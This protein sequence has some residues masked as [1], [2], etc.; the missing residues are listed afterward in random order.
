M[1][2]EQRGVDYYIN[3]IFESTCVI[4]I[5]GIE[6]IMLK[7]L[8]PNRI[9]IK[10]EQVT[11][12]PGGVVMTET[13]NDPELLE[14]RLNNEPVLTDDPYFNDLQTSKLQPDTIT[15]D[16]I[17]EL[18]TAIG[19]VRFTYA[20]DIVRVATLLNE[21][22]YLCNSPRMWINRPTPP[23]ED[24]EKINALSTVLE[25]VARAIN[26]YDPANG[27]WEALMSSFGTITCKRPP[28]F[29]RTTS[30]AAPMGGTSPYVTAADVRRR[31]RESQGF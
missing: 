11:E 15:V 16:G 6:Q 5:T 18:Y 24:I 20:K 3:A 13:H 7:Q 12:L 29:S 30:N 1:T 14:A 10:R 9:R 28:T 25:P 21:Y 4:S 23:A 8:D 31:Y 17:I 2:P 22:N 19:E 26:S 27:T